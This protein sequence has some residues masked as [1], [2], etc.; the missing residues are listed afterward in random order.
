MTMLSARL[1]APLALACALWGCQEE[2]GTAAPSI[3]PPATKT[4]VAER[5]FLNGAIYTADPG[6]RKS[7]RPPPTGP[8]RRNPP[9]YV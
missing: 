5:V 7:R 4:P 3:A 9:A 6:Q 2:P 1:I 8:G